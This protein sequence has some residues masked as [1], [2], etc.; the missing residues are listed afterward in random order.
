MG[1]F[2]FAGALIAVDHKRYHLSNPSSVPKLT[3]SVK[4]SD[5]NNMRMLTRIVE[6]NYNTIRGYV[7]VC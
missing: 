2:Q 3:A 5:K 4:Q 6:H 7:D 1:W